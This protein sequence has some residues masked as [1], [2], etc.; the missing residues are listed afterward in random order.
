MLKKVL[1]WPCGIADIGLI[2][3]WARKVDVTVQIRLFKIGQR[4][5]DPGAQRIDAACR[6]SLPPITFRQSTLGRFIVHRGYADLA[7][8]VDALRSPRGFARG[9]HRRQ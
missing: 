6:G 4:E 9:L 5:R 7:K 2:K 3:K 1:M 8:I